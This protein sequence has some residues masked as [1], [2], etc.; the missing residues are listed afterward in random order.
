M[1]PESAYSM[2]SLARWIGKHIQDSISS[3]LK[4][5]DRFGFKRKTE[6][7]L[8]EYAKTSR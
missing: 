6:M 5:L 7:T 8:S 1:D 2:Y 3:L 4:Q